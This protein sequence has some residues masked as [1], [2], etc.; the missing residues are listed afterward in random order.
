[1]DARAQF[2]QA[3]EEQKRE[4]RRTLDG[5]ISGM[6]LLWSALCAETAGRAEMERLERT[7]HSLAGS[8]AVF[9]YEKL[10]TEARALE[11]RLHDLAAAG[12]I[13][14]RVERAV[15]ARSIAGLREC[16]KESR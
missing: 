13:P 5:R 15:V 1:M 14:G 11:H 6:E 8:G 4:Y 3:L 10:S 9:G 7:A 12:A 16:V 2:M